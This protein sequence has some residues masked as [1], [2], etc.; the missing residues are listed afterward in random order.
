MAQSR[1]TN[2]VIWIT[3][4]ARRVGKEMAL[5]CAR[6]GA[7]IVVHYQ[8]SRAEAEE[9]KAEILGLGVECLVVQGNH[10]V[11]TDVTR[12]VA[13]IDARFGKL[14]VLVNSASVF[15]RIAFELTTEQKLDDILSANLK[16][17]Y[18]CSQLALPLLRK[19]TDP[20]IVNMTDAML[21]RASPKFSA[22]WCAK[23]GLDALT[24][25]LARELAPAIRVNAIAPGP[26]LEP[27]DQSEETRLK[28]LAAIPAGRWGEPRFI[29]D[30]LIYLIGQEF[31]TGTSV[32]VDGGRRLG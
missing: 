10:G 12:M 9:T 4:S 2:R 13:E 28:I 19:G 8:S 25:C 27:E 21:E 26:V 5:A 1:L 32:V 15:P 31:T 18:L 20:Q 14:D 22:Y 17:P 7:H 6:E 3:G 30:A 24:R 29:A 16:G 23:G 11:R